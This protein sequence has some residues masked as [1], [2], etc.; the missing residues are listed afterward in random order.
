LTDHKGPSL[1]FKTFLQ[2]KLHNGHLPEK[3]F[4]FLFAFLKGKVIEK[5][6]APNDP[7]QC[8]QVKLIQLAQ[9]S[10]FP[11]KKELEEIENDLRHLLPNTEFLNDL[12]G[13]I[14]PDKGGLQLTLHDTD[15]YLDLFLCGTVVLGSCQRVDGEPIYNKCLLAYLL[16]GK[17]RLLA[18]KNEHGEMMARSILRL[19]LKEDGQPAL[20]LERIYPDAIS[21]TLKEK[22]VLYAIERAKTLGLN[23]FME[24]E[25][26]F[27]LHSLSCR[28]PWEYVDAG[29]GETNGVYTI[30]KVRKLV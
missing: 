26:P 12:K 29:D 9:R 16:D 25:E 11:S 4:P 18:I 28:A 17:H 27:K 30:R 10:T 2:T 6:E 14:Q 3:D 8:L 19:L 24:G 5:Q 1:S 22:L 15:H 23:L 13:L 21:Q 20:M 7:R